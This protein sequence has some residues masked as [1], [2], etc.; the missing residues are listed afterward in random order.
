MR[1]D[2]VTSASY[3]D[4]IPPVLATR[5]LSVR[6]YG[7]AG[8]LEAAEVVP[9]AELAMLIARMFEDPAIAYLHVHNAR[10][11]CFAARVDRG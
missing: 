8:D 10:P 6:G 4:T 1:R 9:G 11:G 3:V 7:T 2:A 5:L